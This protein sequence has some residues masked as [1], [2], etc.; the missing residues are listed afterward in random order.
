MKSNRYSIVGIGEVL[1]DMLP[2]GKQLGG[3]PANFTYHVRQLGNQ[4]VVVSAIG[5]DMLGQEAERI[6]TERGVN[7]LFGTSTKPTGTVDVVLCEGE[8]TYTIEPDAAWDNLVATQE[9]VQLVERA[10]AICFGSLAQRS[11]IS[12]S[13]IERL[14]AEASTSCLVV[15][16]INLRQ[17]YYSSEKLISSILSSN[18]LKLNRQELEVIAPMVGL[19][20]NLKQKCEALLENF[21]L[22]MVA[23]TDGASG[24][25]L[26]M[27][28]EYSYMDTPKVTV[29]DTVGAG[30]AFTAAIVDG[31]LRG[32]KLADIHRRATDLAAYV[33]TQSGA[34]PLYNGAIKA[35]L[36]I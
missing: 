4:G 20:G 9:M 35:L 14:I 8:P 15:F 18:I 13:A 30:D 3:A 10:D 24:S 26:F 11:A 31:V 5:S 2:S 33:C 6:L 27:G 32:L 1:W 17:K 19:E 28:K 21:G 16:D 36:G 29:V 25:H 34:M 12:G 7:F 22:L 23:L